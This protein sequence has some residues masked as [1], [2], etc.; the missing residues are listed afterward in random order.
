MADRIF[1][2]SGGNYTITL[3]LALNKMIL[4]QRSFRGTRVY[5]LPLDRIKS[6][7]VERKSVVPFA[8]LTLLAAIATFMMG[9]GPF[10]SF[11]HLN[12]DSVGNSTMI[13]A[14]ACAIFVIPSISRILFVNVSVSW[15]GQPSSWLIRL[16]P[17]YSGK[18][19]AKIFSG[20]V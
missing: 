14:L 1:K 19:L 15:D 7:V 13:G 9:Y 8:T 11:M 10:W 18:N 6:V 17:S 4:S 2:C 12:R 20:N 3:D 5:E 16:A